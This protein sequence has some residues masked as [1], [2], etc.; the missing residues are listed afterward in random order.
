MHHHEFAVGKEEIL[1]IWVTRIWV[2]W[3]ILGESKPD[4]LRY[5]G[6]LKQLK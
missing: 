1:K 2:N 4:E 3:W 5:F 6:W